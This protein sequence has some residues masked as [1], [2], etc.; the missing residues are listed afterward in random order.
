MNYYVTIKE[1]GEPA[2]SGSFARRSSAEAEA[3]YRRRCLPQH[4]W[5]I[6]QPE[7]RRDLPGRLA[8]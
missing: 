4:Q 3:A 7:N 1:Q 6:S 2:G 5:G 8:R